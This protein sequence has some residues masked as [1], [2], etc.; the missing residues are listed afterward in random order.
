MDITTLKEHQNID[1]VVRK[2]GE[3]T[4]LELLRCWVEE[5]TFDRVAGITF[6][7]NR[8]IVRTSDRP[9]I[10]NLD[11][12]PYPAYHLFPLEKY[13][14]RGRIFRKTVLP[15]MTSRGCPFRCSFCLASKMVGRML[16]VRT[17]KSVVD[18]LEWLRDE[19][20][21]EAFSFYDDTL[22]FNKER[23]YEIFEQMRRR[24]V[25]LPWNCQTRTDLVSKELL[26]AMKR[27]GCQFVS[28]GVESGSPKLL[29]AMGKGTT[30]KI[31][32]K[33]VKLAKEAGLLVGVSIIIGY[34]GESTETLNETF[35]FIERVKPDAVYLCTPAPYPGTEL[36][37]LV[38]DLGWKMFEDW[39]KYNTVNFAFEN[40]SLPNEF[41][42]K[43]REKFYDSF[44][45][46]RYILRH[47]CKGNLYSGIMARTALNH[48]LWRIRNKFKRGNSRIDKF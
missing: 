1:I 29:K 39:T 34:P 28:F 33:A 9:F 36:Y 19:H 30:V 45:S 43:M 22:T 44:Y 38:K 8:K 13:R 32:E 15:I 24:R 47:F 41:V 20:G 11:K 16:R 3:E 35:A 31:N 37:E 5:K 48:Y 10:Q 46:H 26:V 4:L 2:E 21:A 25:D 27:A 7:K 6:R 14:L 18:E 42:E 12:L 40:P 23:C 17:P